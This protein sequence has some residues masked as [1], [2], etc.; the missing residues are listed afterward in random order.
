MGM[1]DYYEPVPTLRCGRCHEPIEEWQGKDGPC[2]LWLFRQG[3]REAICVASHPERSVE[4]APGPLPESFHFYG[5]CPNGHPM[6]AEGQVGAGVW[7]RTLVLSPPIERTGGANG[8]FACPCCGCFT[9]EDPCTG[10]FEICAVCWWEDDRVQFDDPN[11]HEGANRPSLREGR[12]SYLAVGAADPDHLPHVRPPRREERPGPS[13]ARYGPVGDK[14][15]FLLECSQVSSPSEFWQH[16]LEQVRPYD[17]GSFGRNLDAFWD[18]TCGSDAPGSPGPCIIEVVNLEKLTKANPRFVGVLSRIAEDLR[19]EESEVALHVRVDEPS[20]PSEPRR[21][22]YNLPVFVSQE[23]KGKRIRSARCWSPD[24]AQHAEMLWLEVEGG[25]WHRLWLECGCTWWEEA[26]ESDAFI[27]FEDVDP[28]EFR[29][30]GTE[31]RLIGEV[32]DTIEARGNALEWWVQVELESGRIIRMV[33]ERPEDFESDFQLEIV[34]AVP[35]GRRTSEER[36]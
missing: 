16:Y 15:H 29:D 17:L 1:F 18:A 24:D 14:P 3:E 27:G 32:L 25:H 21:W 8:R 19:A 31:A 35:G 13:P 12:R 30:L 6:E 20:E 4:E 10:S 9:L 22:A 36:S 5:E 28:S 11:H 7:I 23:L 34:E 33:A 26:C 2:G